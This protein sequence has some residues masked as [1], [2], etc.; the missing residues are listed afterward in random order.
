V[1][2]ARSIAARVERERLRA[3]INFPYASAPGVRVLQDLL[4]AGELGPIQR[5][6]VTVAFSEWPQDWQR[7]AR[8]LG[9]REEGGFVREVLCHLV[10]LTQRVLG[11]LEIDTVRIDFPG[12]GRGAETAIEAGLRVG[13][14]PVHV[15][16]WVGSPEPEIHLWEITGAGG[17]CRMPDWYKLERRTDGAWREVEPGPGGIRERTYMTQLDSLAAMLAGGEHPLAGFREGLAVQ[18][19]VEALLRQGAGARG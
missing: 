5:L 7:T 17:A 19:L 15:R 12:D 3:A 2:S 14:V 18:E 16:G 10:F 13:A 8:W 11:P 6:D 4:A 1:E 9:E